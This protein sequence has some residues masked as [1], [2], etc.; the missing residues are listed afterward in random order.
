[1]CLTCRGYKFITKIT[2]KFNSGKMR[3]PDYFLLFL[4]LFTTFGF[5]KVLGQITAPS[6]IYSE[7]TA[8]TN[9]DPVYYFTSVEMQT[10]SVQGPNPSNTYTF[11]W[12]RHRA[13][14]NTW[15]Q[16]AL[17][18]VGS[19]SQLVINEIGG[20]QVR[21][22][23]PGVD[24]IYR[25]WVFEPELGNAGITVVASTCFYLDLKANADTVPLVYYNPANGNPGY[26]NYNRNYSWKASVGPSLQAKS[27]IA[28]NAPVE[29]TRF[30]VT[31]SDKFGNQVTASYDFTA[32]AV[33]SKYKSEII[34]K[35]VPQE[36]H[37][38]VEGSAPIEVRFQDE[39]K[40]NI[41]AWEWRFGRSGVAFNRNPFYVFTAIGKDTVYLKV[42]NRL[43]GCESISVD[44]LVINV[45]GSLL[46]VPNV[47]TPNDDGANDE[48][49]VVY[50]SLKKF[51]IV[52][53]NRWG[54]K[55]Y[56]SSNPAEGWDGSFSGALAP[57]GV[58]F[59]YIEAEGYE[60][61]EKHTRKGSIHLIRGK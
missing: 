39:S 29:N 44:P 57:P 9:P 53:L 19:N 18:Q 10:I 11:E 50:R 56:E 42:I 7:F 17:V 27:L 31:V 23:G 51:H 14:D 32:I 46:E 40:G 47:F 55:V 36:A 26:V 54:R 13:S 3:L 22:T 60:P 8:Y 61:G 6:S 43:S 41:S 30:N 33:L 21:I 45:V 59:Y 28:L 16:P 52:I 2:K 38:I 20:Y 24:L 25:C 49:R 58:Y 12:T 5:N 4:L 34:K 1:M 48:F 35:E 15:S 37:S